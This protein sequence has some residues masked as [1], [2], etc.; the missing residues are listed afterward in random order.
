MACAEG[1]SEWKRLDSDPALTAALQRPATPARV[2]DGFPAAGDPV[3]AR[4]QGNTVPV[5]MHLS[6]LSGII[7]PLGGLIVPLILWLVNR[8]IPRYD[9]QGKE[10]MNWVIFLAIYGIV[11]GILSIVLIGLLMLVVGAVAILVLA[12]MGAV[13]SSKG[14]FFKYPLPFRLIK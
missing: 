6:V 13:K 2:P 8:G 9:A 7:I 10:V 1:A 5:L 4:S 3:A 14:E 12:I 11:S